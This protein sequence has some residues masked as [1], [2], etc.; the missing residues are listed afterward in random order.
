MA[1]KDITGFKYGYLTA[2]RP[3]KKYVCGKTSE[4]M[5]EAKCVCGKIIIKRI[6]QLTTGDNK[7]CGC[8]T[9][10]MKSESKKGDKNPMWA[11]DMVG[12]SS[13]HSWVIRHKPKPEKCERCG[14]VNKKLDLS[15]NGIYNRDLKNWEYICRKCHYWKDTEKQEWHKKCIEGWERARNIKSVE[16]RKKW[17]YC[18]VCKKKLYNNN[19]TGR[20]KQ[21][22]HHKEGA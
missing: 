1:K 19:I 11:G 9:N 14:K 18:E 2:I 10:K 8:M 13:L 5:W 16:A 17:K 4:W 20:C 7:S 3:V 6:G 15:N 22:Q 21:H 12:Y